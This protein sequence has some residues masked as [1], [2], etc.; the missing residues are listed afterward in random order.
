MERLRLIAIEDELAQ[1]LLAGDFEAK[2]SATL[3]ENRQLISDVIEQ[4]INLMREKPRAMPWVGYLAVEAATGEVRGSC[5][6]V[7]GP[8]SSGAIEIA[9]YTF[10]QFEGQGNAVAMASNLL[11][12][13]LASPEVTRIIAY[14][15]PERN[16]ATRV[17]EKSGFAFV[18]DIHDAEHD[19]VWLWHIDRTPRP[20]NG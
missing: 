8:N 14:T 9:Y 19:H 2:Y 12:I 4:T 18:G 13:A 7:D 6:F 20:V 5:A 3:G 17:L 10:P 1:S 11:R 16:A 15:L